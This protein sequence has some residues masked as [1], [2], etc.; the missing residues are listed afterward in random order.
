MADSDR[1]SPPLFRLL[2]PDA[3]LRVR[4]IGLKP[5]IIS[6]LY[7]E[8]LQASWPQLA[9]LFALSFLAF[10]L[11]FAALYS[12]DPNALGSIRE[13]DNIP[14]FWR[15][16]FFSVHTVATIGYGDVYPLSIYANWLVVAEITLGILFFALTT[17]IAFARFSR[18]TARILFSNVAAITAVD[19]IPTF[20]FRAANQRHNLVFGAAASVTA[21]IDEQLAGTT[22]RRFRDLALI[23][24]MNPVFAL[25]W[26]IMHPITEDGAARRSMRAGPMARRTFAATPISPT[27]SARRRTARARSTT[28]GF[29]MSRKASEVDA[30]RGFEPRLTESES[31]VLPLD[32][33]ATLGRRAGR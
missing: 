20:M 21:L 18:P 25:T 19:G 10:N 28:G 17:G 33:R 3:P 23:R 1:P 9:G 14:R 29:T 4:S 32:D 22:M 31:V 2:K 6:D 27:S 8:L 16:F 11:I 12:L 13:L 24:D 15:A 26:T 30:R 5:R 7:H